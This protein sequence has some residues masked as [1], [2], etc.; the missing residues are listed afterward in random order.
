MSNVRYILDD[1]EHLV[2]L[3]SKR[4]VKD[5][6]DVTLTLRRAIL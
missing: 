3:I 1:I 6:L 4:H 5:V 2:S